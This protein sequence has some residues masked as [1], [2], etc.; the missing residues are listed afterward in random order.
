LRLPFR[1]IAF[2]LRS[3]TFRSAVL[4]LGVTLLFPCSGASAQGTEDAPAESPRGIVPPRL[5][6]YVEA[7]IPDVPW[8]DGEDR[9]VLFTITIDAEGRVIEAVVVESAGEAFDRAAQAA[10]LRFR[11]APA[12]KDGTPMASRIQYRYVFEWVAPAPEPPAAARL[13]GRLVDAKGEKPLRGERVRV[14]DAQDETIETITGDDGRFLFGELAPG[15]YRVTV[16]AVDYEPFAVS[17]ELA[18]GEELDVVYRLKFSAVDVPR[19]DYSATAEVEPPPR[20]ITKRTVPKEVLTRVP[21]TRGDPLRAVEILPGVGRPAFATGALIVRGAAP[22]DSQVFLEGVPVPLLYHFGGLTS[23]FQGRLLEELAFYPGNFS[24]Q[25]GRKTGGI[26]NVRVRDPA[27][28]RWKGA[29][30]ISAIDAWILAEGPIGDKVSVALAARR[31]LIDL[32]LPAILSGADLSVTSAPVYY[33]HQFILTYKPTSRDRI[34]LMS[35]GASD[36]FAFIVGEE[37]AEDPN[38][39][40][41]AELRQR[42]YF[43][44]LT[45][46]RDLNR[47]FKQ[48]MTFAIGPSRPVF[49]F[50][51]DLEFDARFLDMTLRSEWRGRLSKRFETIV[52]TDIRAVPY[53]IRYSGPPIRQTEG[54]PP[55]NQGSASERVV[56]EAGDG[57]L[58]QPGVYG[59][60]AGDF[61]PVRVV[62]GLRFDYVSSANRAVLDP[63]LNTFHQVNEKLRLKAG[64][65]MYSQPPA[66]QETAP[67]IGNPNLDFIRS[68]HTSAG[69]DYE[70][71]K[72]IQVGLEGFYKYLWNR[73]VSTV[74]GLPPFFVNE[75][76]GRIYGLEVSGKIEPKGRNYFGYLSYTLSRSERRDLEGQRY[77]L[78]DFDQPHIFT[79]LFSY[80]FKRN[81]EL[82]A[83]VRLVSGNPTTPIIGSFYDGENDVYIPIS[84]AINSV[85]NPLFHR[86]DVRVE[87]T[88]IWKHAKLAVFLDIQNAYYSKNQEGRLYGFDYSQSVVLEGLPIIPALGIRG[89]L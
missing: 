76:I 68:V 25:Y 55:G 42:F 40:G 71:D 64:V 58:F 69:G 66:V 63:R 14:T 84:G 44:T 4:V 27:S 59:E 2:I 13:A 46:D 77:R 86:L 56:R 89:E 53:R 78:F 65:G 67:N 28:D 29:V 45:W 21:G 83:T 85:R 17:E 37:L 31:S 87:K 60:V 1:A 74:G 3:V 51:P 6:E 72:G 52:G 18:P 20:E 22:A 62:L 88:W 38:I 33:D 34:R 12:T 41:A 79:A 26:L 16:A 43:T 30:E 15:T 54:A 50:G 48:T 35:Y 36:A 19:A 8:D 49:R 24:A 73:P 82:G 70:V 61:D 10:V 39:R 81:W 11:F 80:R 75:G 5:L 23:F 47:G 7:E 57:V 9:A 32:I